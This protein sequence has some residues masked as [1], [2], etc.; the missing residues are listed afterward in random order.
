[1]LAH[2]A[3]ATS[4]PVEQFMVVNGRRESHIIDRTTGHG[5]RS[6]RVATVIGTD[7]ALVDATA[8]ALTVLPDREGR[9]LLRQL[10]LVG[11][12]LNP[13]DN[14]SRGPAR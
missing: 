11:S 3:L 8:T 2:A 1:S 4:G 7:A 12:V 13:P 6:S 9:R 10:R 14:V 5:V